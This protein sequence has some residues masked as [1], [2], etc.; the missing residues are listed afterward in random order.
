MS[1]YG[2]SKPLG[3]DFFDGCLTNIGWLLAF[4]AT[5]I[6]VVSIS[7]WYF[8][9]PDLICKAWK[10]FDEVQIIDNGYRKE[11]LLVTKKIC[12]EWSKP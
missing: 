5:V 1:S 2:R 12:T 10:D 8:N 6:S 4:G 3:S 11:Q 9:P 7:M